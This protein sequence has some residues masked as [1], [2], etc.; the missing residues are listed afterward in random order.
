MG[1]VVFRNCVSD[2]FF[3]R[4]AA[5]L[6]MGLGCLSKLFDFTRMLGPDSGRRHL[7]FDWIFGMFRYNFKIPQNAMVSPSLQPG[8]HR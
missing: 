1:D 5:N 7:G 3:S 4:L 2:L 8:R 6:G